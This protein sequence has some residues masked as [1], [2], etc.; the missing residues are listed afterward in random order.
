MCG[1]ENEAMQ[2]VIDEVMP[3]NRPPCKHRWWSG[4]DAGT[5]CLDCGE[6]KE[7]I[8][9]RG[10]YA[11]AIELLA[12]IGLLHVMAGVHKY[13]LFAAWGR[14]RAKVLR[15]PRAQAVLQQTALHKRFVELKE[16]S[17]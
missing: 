3:A 2:R 13:K 1:N 15:T 11:R 9:L 14:G 10:E 5:F 4:D 6:D 16:A 8:E 7:V 17:K 12:E